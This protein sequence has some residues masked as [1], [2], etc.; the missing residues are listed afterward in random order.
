MEKKLDVR[1]LIWLKANSNKICKATDVEH[2]N[3]KS[4]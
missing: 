3:F 4:S 1:V 2:I